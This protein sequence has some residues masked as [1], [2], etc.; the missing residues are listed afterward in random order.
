MEL[1]PG[2]RLGPY[3]IVAPI[4]VGGMGEVY[5]ARDTR[6]GRTVA[7]KV[8]TQQL[9][10]DPRFRERFEREAHTVSQLNHPNI[11][12][13][14]DVG[15]QDGVDFLVME[16]VRGETLA[17]RIRRGPVPP[18]EALE[19]LNQMAQALAEAHRL[20]IVHR[21]IKP[22]NVMLTSTGFVKVLDF[23]LAKVDDRGDITRTGVAIGT[24]AYMAPEQL[25]AEGRLGPETD[26][27]ALGVVLYEVLSGTRP[28]H[29]SSAVGLFRSIVSD[30]PPPID[31]GRLDVPR[32]LKRLIGRAMEKDANLRHATAAEFGEELGRCRQAV[33]EPTTSARGTQVRKWLIAAACVIALIA[34]VVATRSIVK[35]RRAGWA[36]SEAIPQIQRLAERGEYVAAF[37]LAGQ[38]GAYLGDDPALAALWP[39]ISVIG[40]WHTDPPGARVSFKE[41]SAVDAEWQYLGTTPIVE[42]RLPRGTF[43]FMVSKDGFETVHL[44]RAL[45]VDSPA[46][47]LALAAAGTLGDMVAVPGDT[48]PVNLS[49]FNTEDLVEIGPFLIDRTEV[50]NR[51]F[52]EFVDAG[53][54]TRPE[55][56]TD[57]AHPASFSDSTRRPGPAGWELGE[58]AAG[59]GDAPV[60]GVSWYEAA[61]YCRF[62]NKRLPTLYHWARAALA[63]HE[64]TAPLGP[65]H[66]ASQQLQRQ[67]ARP[68]WLLQQHGTVRHVRHRRQCEGVVMERVNGGTAV[69]PRRELDRSRLHVQRADV[70][71]ARRP[72]GDEWFPMHADRGGRS[73][74][75]APDARCRCFI[76]GLP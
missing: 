59:Q 72:A 32:R 38:A 21:D 75:G 19:I 71:A 7:I 15:H 25:L 64:I 41:Y 51:A 40:S 47:H 73:D 31:E 14:H 26:V 42:S 13:L 4:G 76:A 9:A 2:V 27:W 34:G 65:F 53:G 17:E 28:F 11:C 36:R 55:G 46:V 1:A 18:G 49:G 22:A 67:G 37:A 33:L 43:R 8:I 16:F 52:K 54:Y 5:E 12:T 3:E 58:Y 69:D 60:G 10:S 48:L 39:V 20:G 50:T 45:T 6:L 44:A 56:W 35:A 74:R 63:P 70:A 57:G 61:A 68:G 29:A 24:L 62:R 66:R 23:G 30:T